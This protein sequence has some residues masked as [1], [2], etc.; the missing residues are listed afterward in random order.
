[1][2]YGFLKELWLMKVPKFTGRKSYK[3]EINFIAVTEETVFET[4]LASAK[5][6]FLKNYK[7]E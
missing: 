2:R 7:C 1:M 4:K 5:T 6:L 3:T